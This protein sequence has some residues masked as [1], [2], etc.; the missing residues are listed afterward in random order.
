MSGGIWWVVASMTLLLAWPMHNAVLACLAWWRPRPTRDVPDHPRNLRFWIVIPALNEERVVG[1]TV[2][3]A[4]ALDSPATPVRVL[5]VDDGSTDATPQILA[6][7]Q[8]PRL[9]VLRRDLPDA[10]KGKGEA[11]NAAYQLIRERA[12]TERT[13]HE[14]V[15]GVIDGDGRGAQ[16]MLHEVAAY[17][18]DR[19]VGGVQCRVRI[20]NRHHLL[21]FVQDLEFS[22]V[23]DASQSLRDVLGSVDLGGNGQFVRLSALLRFGDRPWSGCLVEDLELGLRLHLAGVRIRYA[24]NAVVTQQA[25]V[26]PR[27]LVRQRTR[28]GQGNLQCLGY[29]PRLGFS[30]FVRGPAL[31]DFGYYLLAPWL[32]VPMSLAVLGLVGTTVSGW[33]SGDRFD[34]LV[35]TGADAPLA[36][37]IWLAA[38]IGPGLLWGVVHRLRLGDEPLHR[39]LLVG[40]VYPAFLMLGVLASWRALGRHL[41][42]R[43]AWS[44]T[45]RLVEKPA[46]LLAAPA[47]GAA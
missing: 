16:N 38:L 47:Q 32:M 20:H 7:I 8:D 12:T 42:G 30:R 40:L 26:D 10:R 27:R 44:K 19:G 5:V 24:T 13:V 35:A 46:T 23:A 31:L 21:A 28:W 34:G 3:A 15:V 43:N 9:H 6:G 25:V 1:A 18:A 14:T 36:V 33:I 45:E 4:L 17:F 2:A 37:A 39:T 11:L 41:A 29:L 22:C